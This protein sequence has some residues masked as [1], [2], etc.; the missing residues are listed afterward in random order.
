[1]Q[2]RVSYKLLKTYLFTELQFT[3]AFDG[4]GHGQHQGVA[5]RTQ[6][7]RG[8]LLW[9]ISLIALVFGVMTIKEGGSVLFFDGPARAA[10]GHYVPFVLWFNFI[11]G[12][13]YVVA[14]AGLWLQRRWAV[15]LAIFI[16]VATLVVFAAFAVH[17]AFGGAY[18]Q[19]TP[20]AMALR[21]VVWIVIAAI[22]GWRLRH[23]HRF[24]IGNQ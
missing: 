4:H 5:M 10:A 6:D 9:A 12:F 21:S 1:M 24:E 17:I 8:L 16:A 3:H 20:I 11:A 13:A 15:R 14:G 2:A 23:R 22:G 19:R 18:A 7:H